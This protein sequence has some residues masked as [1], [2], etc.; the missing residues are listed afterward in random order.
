MLHSFYTLIEK[1]LELIARQVDEG[2]PASGAWHRDLLEQ[3]RRPT[4]DRGAV[5]S[6]DLAEKLKEYLAFRHLFAARPLH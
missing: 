6:D 2:V 5:I 4:A 3:M 1:I